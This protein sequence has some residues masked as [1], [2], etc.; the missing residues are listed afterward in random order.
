MSMKIAL[1]FV[2]SLILCVTAFSQSKAVTA[3]QVNGIYR[4]R[5]NEIRIFALGHNK[6]RIQMDLAWQYT[7]DLGPGANTGTSHGEATIENDVATF[8]PEDT[9]DC[10]IT[11]KFLKGNKIQVSEDHILNCGWGF[12]VS[13]EGTYRKIRAGKPKFDENH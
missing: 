5:L 4:H 9:E 3:A 11:I 6:L 8:R 10:T 12:N 13:S 2:C 1:S 7:N